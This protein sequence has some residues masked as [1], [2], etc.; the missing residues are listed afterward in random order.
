LER[1]RAEEIVQRRMLGL[2]QARADAMAE[3][4]Q[5][6]ELARQI[7]L[8]RIR[9]DDTSGLEDE[10]RLRDRVRELQRDQE[11]SLQEATR[12]AL[13][14]ASDLSRAEMQ[15]NFRDAFRGGLQTAMNGDLKGF[16]QNWME[17]ASFNALSRVLDRIADRLGDLLSGASSGGGGLLGAIGSLFG[18]GGSSGALPTGGLLGGGDGPVFDFKIPGF[19]NG[20]S[21]TLGGLAGIDRNLLSLNGSPIAKVSAGEGLTITP[22]NDRGKSGDT[23]SNV[24]ARGSHDPAAVEAAVERGIARAAPTLIGTSVQK[25]IQ[26]IGRRRLPGSPRR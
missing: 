24:D 23:Y 5:D 20:G 18:G 26:T 13:A 19:A 16:F 10:A 3:R 1:A 12:V 9:G 8:G 11:L 4:A 17:D 6:Q 25:T 14:E 7:E 15:G 22:A 2:E 21:G